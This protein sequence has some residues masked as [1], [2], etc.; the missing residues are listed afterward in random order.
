MA[1]NSL[2]RYAGLATQFFVAIGVAVFAG[3]K[4]DKIF[5]FSMPLLVWILPLTIIVFIIIK[6]IK[7]TGKK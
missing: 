4:M 1:D 5:S 3:L 7:D 6:I 2:W